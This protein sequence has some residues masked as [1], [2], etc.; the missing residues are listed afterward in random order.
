MY[1]N[2]WHSDWYITC[3]TTNSAVSKIENRYH[4]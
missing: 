2:G 3:G 4:L 1:D